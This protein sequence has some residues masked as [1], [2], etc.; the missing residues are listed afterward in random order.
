MAK[1]PEP[2][3]FARCDSGCF[4]P[5][6]PEKWAVKLPTGPPLSKDFQGKFP[7]SRAGGLRGRGFQ[8]MHAKSRMHQQGRDVP[9]GIAVLSGANPAGECK[10]ARESGFK[11]EDNG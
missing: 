11:R 3:R 7:E 2:L 4:N 8:R 5:S 9:H 10:E 6:I 1:T